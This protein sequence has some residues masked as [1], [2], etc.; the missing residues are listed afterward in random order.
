MVRGDY[1]SPR[2]SFL[3]RLGEVNAAATPLFAN[4]CLQLAP[5]PALCV[6]SGDTASRQVVAAVEPKAI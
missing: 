5:S 3:P 1:L 4:P 2:V 6:L